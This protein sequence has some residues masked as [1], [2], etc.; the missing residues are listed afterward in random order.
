MSG[1]PITLGR[2][3]AR[4]RHRV[5]EPARFRLG[6]GPRV[7]RGQCA[8][9]VPG[10][11]GFAVEGDPGASAGI[12]ADSEFTRTIERPVVPEDGYRRLLR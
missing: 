3:A 2:H 9:H 7:A 4:D 1:M 10:H 5:G 8:E 12:Q 6:E 11:L